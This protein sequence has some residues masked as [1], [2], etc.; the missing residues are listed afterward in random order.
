MVETTTCETISDG[1]LHEAGHCVAA[2]SYGIGVRRV[3]IDAGEAVIEPCGIYLEQGRYHGA[4]AL[5]YAV[6][7]LAGRAAAPTTSL[8]KS[9]E[10]LL[11]QAIFLGSWAH[12]P[13]EMCRAFSALANSFVLDHRKEIETLATILDRRRSMSGAEVEEIIRSIGQ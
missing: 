11:D 7:A 4:V 13:D 6:V 8:S 9:D 10:L 12:P 5:G 2:L 1:S 3:C